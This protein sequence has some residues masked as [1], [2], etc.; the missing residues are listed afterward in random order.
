MLNI[1]WSEMLIVAAIALI[2]VGPKDLPVM[3][4]QL[5]RVFGTVRRMGNEFKSEISKV[6]ALDEVKDIKNSITAPLKET[7]EELTNQFNTIGKDGIEPSGAIKP[8]V[9]GQE[10]VADEIRESSGMSA[11]P[12]PDPEAAA[13]SMKAAI[14][15]AKPNTKL[16]AKSAAANKTVA[17]KTAAKQKPA[18]S[19]PAAKKT[20]E[21]KKTAPA[22]T[23]AAKPVAKATPAKKPTARKPKVAAAAKPKANATA[24]SKASAPAKKPAAR[25]PAAAKSTTRT[26]RAPAKKPAAP[27]GN[28]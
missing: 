28:A 5:G 24:N 2:V 3:L 7:H 1:G 14:S 26:R 8:K 23:V 6:A 10:S 25:K 18:A 20:T 27:K 15:R 17:N 16:A 9:D 13:S 12:Q 22:K 19:K 4:R 11:I 21:P